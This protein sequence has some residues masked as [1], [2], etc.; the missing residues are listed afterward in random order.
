MCVPIPECATVGMGSEAF[1]NCTRVLHSYS[2]GSAHLSILVTRPCACSHTRVHDWRGRLPRI[3]RQACPCQGCPCFYCTGKKA[4]G[5]AGTLTRHTGHADAHRHKDESHN[6]P[7]PPTTHTPHV[8]ATTEAAADSTAASPK[9]TAPLASVLCFG[10]L[11]FCVLASPAGRVFCVFVF[12]LARLRAVFCVFV[13]WGR[14]LQGHAGWDW[15]FFRYKNRLFSIQDIIIY[16]YISRCYHCV[17]L[18]II[19]DI[20]IYHV[21]RRHMIYRYIIFF[22]SAFNIMCYHADLISRS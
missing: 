9:P 21:P 22:S 16:P 10:A 14:P 12:G 7:N 6:Q 15:G 18:C 2:S 5:G 17:S 3:H 8:S 1:S 4:P 13:F 20:T 19:V 11:C